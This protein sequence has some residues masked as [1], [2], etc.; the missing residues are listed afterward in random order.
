MNCELVPSDFGDLVHSLSLKKT[1]SAVAISSALL[2]ASARSSLS[3]GWELGQGGL[4]LVNVKTYQIKIQLN[5]ERMRTANPKNHHVYNVYILVY[6]R[7][8]FVLKLLQSKIR[9]QSLFEHL[10]FTLRKISRQSC[11]SV[12]QI[13]S[14][15]PNK[16]LFGLFKSMAMCCTALG[17]DWRERFSWP[18][19]RWCCGSGFQD[20]NTSSLTAS[21][22]FDEPGPC[23]GQGIRHLSSPSDST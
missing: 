1:C 21:L 8:K 2:S 4:A 10:H 13:Y 7:C 19:L 18:L 20:V 3:S 22:Q 16:N 17:S 11:C 12:S 6:N 9:F 5:N 15:K 14:Q 23:R